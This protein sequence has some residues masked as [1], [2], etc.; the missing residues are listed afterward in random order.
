MA[1]TKQTAIELYR[2]A[3]ELNIKANHN[4]N[5]MALMSIAKRWYTPSEEH[6]SQLEAMFDAARI[7]NERFAE[8]VAGMEANQIVEIITEA[9]A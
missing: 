7:A 9:T 5:K 3:N 6:H 1:N 8:S 4:K 2:T